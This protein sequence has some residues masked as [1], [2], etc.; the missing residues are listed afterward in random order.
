MSW[1]MTGK[2][3]SCTASSRGT[4]VRCALESST[5]MVRSLLLGADGGS[6]RSA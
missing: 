6:L 4:L 1:V 2:T 5:E 3:S